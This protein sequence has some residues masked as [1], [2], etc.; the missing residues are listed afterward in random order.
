MQQGGCAQTGA[1]VRCPKLKNTRANNSSPSVYIR[2]KNDGLF[3]PHR[4]VEE[5]K[6]RMPRSPAVYNPPA[7]HRPST[8]LWDQVETT[9]ERKSPF[10]TPAA[11]GSPPKKHTQC[12]KRKGGPICEQI[13]KWSPSFVSIMRSLRSNPAA[14]VIILHTLDAT[15]RRRGQRHHPYR[16]SSSRGWL[17]RRSE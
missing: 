10:K 12:R 11:T 4:G 13:N 17:Y 14:N 7:L 1:C 15:S 9:G 2:S 6:T 8:G 3:K 5:G 16:L